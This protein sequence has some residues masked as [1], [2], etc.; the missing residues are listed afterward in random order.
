MWG[1]EH[2]A[3]SLDAFIAAGSYGF[4]IELDVRDHRGSVVVAHDPPVGDELEFRSVVSALADASRRL[5]IAINVKADGLG[6]VTP[7]V[8]CEVH[9]LGRQFLEEFT[10]WRVM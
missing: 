6:G 2:P 9:R 10:V 5:P 3:N 4:G 7:I 8:L 1:T